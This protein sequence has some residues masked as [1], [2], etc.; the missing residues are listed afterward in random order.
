[1]ALALGWFNVDA[2]MGTGTPTH[3]AEWR[4]F[5]ALE[6]WGDDWERSSLITARTLNTL[7]GIASSMGGKE[8]SELDAIDDDAFVPKRRKD[9][10][11]KRQADAE[12][13]VDIAERASQEI[14]DLMSK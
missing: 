14:Y 3:L 2:M 8:I 11:T 5:A 6:P 13:G 1:M 7:H 12:K 4:E 9:T 10:R